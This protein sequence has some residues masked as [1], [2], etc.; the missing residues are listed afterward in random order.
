MYIHI[1]YVFVCL[2]TCT[3]ARTHTYMYIE[4]YLL[5]LH[6]IFKVFINLACVCAAIKYNI[7][8][9]RT[10]QNKEVV[11]SEVRGYGTEMY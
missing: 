3:H 1:I 10:S 5:D 7:H 9:P 2:H 11:W 6:D 4:E 8:R